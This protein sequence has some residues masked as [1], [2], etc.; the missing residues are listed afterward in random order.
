MIAGNA[1][2]LVTRVIYVKEGEGKTFVIVDAAMNDL[3]RPTLYDAHHDIKPVAEPGRDARA[4]RGRRRRAGLRDRR[5]PRARPRD[6]GGRGR[7]PARR[8]DRRRLRGGP[9]RHL[10]HPPPR[11]GGAGRRTAT[12]AVVRPRPT[13]ED[14]DRPRP[15]AA[16][17]LKAPASRRCR[18]A[19]RSRFCAHLTA[20]Q[21]GSPMLPWSGRGVERGQPRAMETW[22]EREPEPGVAQRRDARAQRLQRGLERLVGR[23]RWTLWWERAWPL[24]WVPLADRSRLPDRLLARPLAR[25]VAA[26]ARR[27]PCA[28]SPRPLR[29]LA[30]AARAPSPAGP[31]RSALDRLDRDAG[32][33]HGPARA[34]DDTLALGHATP[35]PAPCGSCTA[36]AP[37]RRSPAL[38]VAAPPRTCRGATAS[39]LRA[40]GILAVVASA[41]VAG[42]EIGSRL[43]AAFDWREPQAARAR[44]S[45]STAGSTRRSTPARRR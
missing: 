34:L 22:H 40:A 20:G 44:A 38:R 21:R 35:E 37:R 13:Y 8:H 6:A 27:R 45:G 3:I 16:L 33:A 1:G 42:P 10:Q 24:L 39:P 41:F 18:P 28:S 29:R 11:A 5:L 9:G 25:R 32:L 36:G 43:A 14:A 12:Y 19:G 2:I 7:R 17:A 26:H 31:R 4:D 30:L 15:D 23:A